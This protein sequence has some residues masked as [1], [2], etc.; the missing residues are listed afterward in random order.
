[1]PNGLITQVRRADELST[2]R[3]RVTFSNPPVCGCDYA[4]PGP[5]AAKNTARQPNTR[6]PLRFLQVGRT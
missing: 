5:G 4:V 6:S 1:M 2:A 3:R